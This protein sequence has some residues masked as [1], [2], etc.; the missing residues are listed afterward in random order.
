MG[1][2]IP[3]SFELICDSHTAGLRTGWAHWF[4]E[5]ENDL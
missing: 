3:V 1:I 2:R 4:H 5:I